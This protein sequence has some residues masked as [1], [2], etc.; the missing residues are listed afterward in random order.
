MRQARAAISLIRLGH[1]ERVWPLLQHSSDPG[2]RSFIINW[3][4]PLRVEPAVLAAELER[5]NRAHESSASRMLE[6]LFDPEISKRR[7]LILALGTYDAEQLAVDERDRLTSAL[8]DLYRNDVD[9]GIHSAADWTLRRWR[10][11]KKKLQALDMELQQLKERGERRWWV[12]SQRQTLAVL[13]G[14]VEFLMGAPKTDPERTPGDEP[15][16]RTEIPRRFCITTKE[17]TVEQFRRFL[18]DNP[19]YEIAQK[20]LDQYSPDPD[21]PWIMAAWYMCAHYCN[22]LSKQEGLKEA[23]WCY[24]PKKNGSY[25]EGMTIPADMLDR[26]GYRLPTEAEW[27]Y[28]CR[29]GAVTSR[30]F[31]ASI[32]IMEKYEWYNGNSPERTGPVGSLLPNDLGMFDVLGNVFELCHNKGEPLK[33]VAEELRKDVVAGETLTD[34]AE[35]IVRGGAFTSAPHDLRSA[36]RSSDAP[37]NASIYNGFRVARTMR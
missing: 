21:G 22:W 25:E 27:E 33:A 37:V 19:S 36:H 10:A 13:N 18:S 14:P 30:Y 9:A 8:L 34:S 23:D 29:A 20:Y 11:P 28:A 16:S 26:K 15:P 35:R 4:K 24:I 6:V 12:N 7:A 5:L 31:G 3:L 1:P 32:A 2:L 17:V